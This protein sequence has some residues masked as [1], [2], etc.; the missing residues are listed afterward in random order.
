MATTKKKV[1]YVQVSGAGP[2][3]FTYGGNPRAI[4]TGKHR[5]DEVFPG[6]EHLVGHLAAKF[7]QRVKVVTE[8]E[9]VELPPTTEE[10]VA[11][12]VKRVEIVPELI[13]RIATLEELV[14]DLIDDKRSDEAPLPTAEA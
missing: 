13:Q 11:E 14:A 10:V 5:V 7:P 3:L 8:Y 2:V 12:L 6:E 9:E 4:P 1:Q